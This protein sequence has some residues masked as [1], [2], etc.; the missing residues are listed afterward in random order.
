MINMYDSEVGMNNYS[1]YP[2]ERMRR[3]DHTGRTKRDVK[4][5]NTGMSACVWSRKM[6]AVGDER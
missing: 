3:P 4:A 2:R 5:R 6:I 1:R